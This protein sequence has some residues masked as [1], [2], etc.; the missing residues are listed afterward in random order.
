MIL[1]TKRSI[2]LGEN[3][4]KPQDIISLSGHAIVSMS[5]G[6]SLFIYEADSVKLVMTFDVAP[7]S[8]IYGNHFIEPKGNL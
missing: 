4:K 1:L 2:Y 3:D 6:S 8:F 7:M 5:K